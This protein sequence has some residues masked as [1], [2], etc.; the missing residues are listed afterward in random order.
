MA[1]KQWIIADCDKD[2]AANIAQKYGIDP[3]AALLAVSRGVRTD[4]EIRSFFFDS[5]DCF[6]DPFLYK[7]MDRA[8]LRVNRALDDFER[9]AVFGDYDADGV[10]ATAILSLYFS[11]R[12][13]NFFYLLPER[14]E[15][16]GLN[17]AV[18]D[19]L[20][21][22]GTKLIITVDNGIN[23]VEEA[24]YAKSL[25]IDMVITDHHQ[26]GDALPD[27]A[28]VVDPHRP[29]CTGPSKELAGVG[30]AFKLICALEGGDTELLL[31]EYADLVAIGTVA[32]IVPLTGE[33]RA[34]VRRGLQ[35]MND[36]PRPGIA[37]MREAGGSAEKP[38][39]STSVAFTLSPRLNAVGRM[40]SAMRALD[41][42]LCDDE[43][44]AADLAQLTERAN[45]ERQKTEQTILEAAVAQ[46]S[47]NPA[48]QNDRVLVVD[49]ENWHRGV[50]GIVASRMVE[51]YGKPCIVISR[52]D[53]TARGSGRSIE[54]FSLYD[55]L[56]ACADMLLQYGGH[57]LAA[58][59]SVDPD[60][61]AAF[62][63]AINRY[64]ARTEMPFPVQHIDMKLNPAFIKPDI[65]HAL[66]TLEPFGAANPKPVFGLF[67]MRLDSVTPLA[68]GKHVRLNV[69]KKG[70]QTAVLCFG[71]S[72]QAFPFPV[73]STLDFAV[74]LDPNYYMGE[75]RVSVLAKHIRFSALAGDDYLRAQ[76][77]YTAIC[78]GQPIR[79]VPVSVVPDRTQIGVIYKALRA[80]G[81]S[82]RSIDALCVLTGHTGIS[83]CSVRLAADAL[84][85]LGLAAEADD[86]TLQ[87]LPAA[88]K[89]DL[90]TSSV[91]QKARACFGG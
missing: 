18:I 61:I 46:L 43:Q 72:P 26:V 20:H 85:E 1:V 49:G 35:K 87:L 27:A 3:L 34:L 38:F 39:T 31:D 22:E 40:G 66:Q 45:A 37:A 60:N 36:S 21:A 51:K 78:R 6:S 84:C 59:L 33:N 2:L 73:G 76:R 12:E 65:L 48:M 19:R 28:A 62:R 5:E 41:I 70:A 54:G 53:G 82:V 7:D 68:G 75:T 81:G 42:L 30:V 17:R 63:T 91:L 14:A 47:E 79:T 64:A 83:A 9:I 52:E 44:T 74:T 10:T 71:V 23:A 90:E 16:Y 77:L 89:T 29:D 11:M 25:G 15:G 8:V 56:K 80:A 88:G 13:A 86:G 67:S 50:I 24:A 55:A 32:D 4:E 58:G 69:S 57:T